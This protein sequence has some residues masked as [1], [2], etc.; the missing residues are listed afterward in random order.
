MSQ[1][2]SPRPDEA[3]AQP[4]DCHSDAKADGTMAA[5]PVTPASA[6]PV[7]RPSLVPFGV[8]WLIESRDLRAFVQ[9]LRERADH[10]LPVR[11]RAMREIAGELE[12]RF[13]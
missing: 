6:V 11:C 3:H 9:E 13:L 4:V 5:A 12:A 7:G 1:F 8:E 10:A 2:P